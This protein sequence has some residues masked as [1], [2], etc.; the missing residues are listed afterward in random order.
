MFLVKTCLCNQRFWHLNI[1]PGLLSNTKRCVENYN[2]NLFVSFVFSNF[3]C[4]FDCLIAL[5]IQL[6]YLIIWIRTNKKMGVLKKMKFSSAIT[7][8]SRGNHVCPI[9]FVWRNLDL[10]DNGAKVKYEKVENI[11]TKINWAK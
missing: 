5:I 11:R 2:Y 7:L 8:C 3:N 10:L 9:F 4:K 6:C 1:W